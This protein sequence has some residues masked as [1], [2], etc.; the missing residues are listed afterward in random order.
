[1]KKSENDVFFFPFTGH[2]AWS[3]PSTIKHWN[4]SL[5]TKLGFSLTSFLLF[6][7]GTN[8]DHLGSLF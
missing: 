1:M 3:L 6:L 2:Q 7:K 8:L 5:A 4:L